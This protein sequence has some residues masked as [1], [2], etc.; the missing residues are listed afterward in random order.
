MTLKQAVKDFPI[1]ITDHQRMV[2]GGEVAK[3][4]REAGIRIDRI[5]EGDITVNDYPESF[6]M[7]I[8]FTLITPASKKK[9]AR[10]VRVKHNG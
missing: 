7:G 4:A 1:P 8:N 3:I 9:R 6:I 10:I 2:L 5:K